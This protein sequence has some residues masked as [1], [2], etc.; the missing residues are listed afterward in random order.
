MGWGSVPLLRVARST[1]SVP[2]CD[3]AASPLASEPER[4]RA[5]AARGAAWLNVFLVVLGV[6]VQVVELLC[7]SGLPALYTRIL[8]TR[9]PNVRPTTRTSCR[10]TPTYMVDD[11]LVLL[12]VVH[13][14][15]SAE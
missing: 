11:V 3:A 7:T 15:P 12:G 6:L 10:T 9:A 1:T 2:S 5:P 14:Q 4:R 8:T 13:A